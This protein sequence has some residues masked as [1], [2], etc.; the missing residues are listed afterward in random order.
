VRPRMRWNSSQ[1]VRA[2]KAAGGASNI[3]SRLAEEQGPAPSVHISS[4]D[5]SAPAQR[6]AHT[7]THTH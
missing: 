5:T 7:S 1:G 6:R 3:S 2:F 4:C